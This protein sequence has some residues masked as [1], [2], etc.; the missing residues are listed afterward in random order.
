MSCLK[1]DGASALSE[2]PWEA[3]FRYVL[4][5]LSDVAK[6]RFSHIM[7]LSTSCSASVLCSLPVP[8]LKG[9]G[10][11]SVW[12]FEDPRTCERQ[13]NNAPVLLEQQQ[14]DP[15]LVATHRTITIKNAVKGGGDG[16]G[17]PA[18]DRAKVDG[19]ML[20]SP[21][22]PDQSHQAWAVVGTFTSRQT[23]AAASHRGVR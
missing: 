22:P 16:G 2:V 8:I 19:E 20:G 6:M 12:H 21:H 3:L 17:D 18:K 4:G 5:V 23:A 15:P 1:N 7:R 13:H 14:L 9:Q 10:S 11:C